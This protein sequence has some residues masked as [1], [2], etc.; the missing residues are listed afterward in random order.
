M[1]ESSCRIRYLHG[2]PLRPTCSAS[3][4]S[5]AQRVWWGRAG[6]SP[7]TFLPLYEFWSL[8]TVGC[9]ER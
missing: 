3:G 2:R 8:R 9:A 7:A 1:V 5:G 6:L 4:P